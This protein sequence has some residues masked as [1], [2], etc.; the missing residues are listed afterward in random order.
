MRRTGL[1]LVAIVASACGAAQPVDRVV[2]DSTGPTPVGTV[3][4]APAATAAGTPA[5]TPDVAAVKL[6]EFPV[7][8]GQGPHDVAPA[9]DG[10]VW[11]TAQRTGELGYLDP[12]TGAT[13]MVK[14]GSGSA[15]HGV[16]VGPDGAPWVTD[17]G[18]NAIVR[19][20]PTSRELNVFRLPGPNVNL[21][22]AAFDRFGI[23]WFTGQG[24]Y[25]G[26]VDPKTGVVKVLQSPRG[27]GPY[28]ITATPDGAIFYASLAN[29][30][31]ASVDLKEDIASPIDPPTRGQ[32]ARRVWSD[33]RGRIW[34]SEWNAGQ[35]GLYDT[36]SRTWREWKL[37]GSDPMTYAVYVDDQDIVWLTDFGA[38]AIVRFDPRAETF[39]S[40]PHAQPNAAVRQLLGRPGE[41]WGAM[42]G[43]DK[44]L[45]IRTR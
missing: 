14:L 27:A 38:N 41:V 37:P 39:R 43:Q 35:V 12:K 42:S 30:H 15:P 5:A 34:V 22:T 36:N 44:L 13:R 28:G 1:L 21:N 23:L 24:G 17:G 29:S 40:Y 20:D 6:T 33:S 10:G 8:R 45:L 32:G 19:V 3:T 31:I 26:H 4:A 16:I 7:G 2:R 18:L 9:P 25:F 11:Y